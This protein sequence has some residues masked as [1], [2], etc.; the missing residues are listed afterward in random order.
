MLR[1]YIKPHFKLNLNIEANTGTGAEPILL[2]LCEFLSAAGFKRP[3]KVRKKETPINAAD[4]KTTQ[5]EESLD[6]VRSSSSEGKS[7][8]KNALAHLGMQSMFRQIEAAA[9]R[10]TQNV[11]EK[12]THEFPLLVLLDARLCGASAVAN[13][14]AL[15]ALK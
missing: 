8:T 10:L 5:M 4:G 15:Y 13:I 14:F 1:P 11:E 12:S 2:E 9:A 7:S 6:E 3:P